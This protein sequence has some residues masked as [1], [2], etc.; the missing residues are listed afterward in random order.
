MIFGNGFLPFGSALDSVD[1]FL[2]LIGFAISR[3]RSCSQ[4]STLPLTNDKV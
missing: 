3:R 1:F 4:G 2:A